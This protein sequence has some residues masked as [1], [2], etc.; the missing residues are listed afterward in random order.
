MMSIPRHLFVCAAF[1]AIAGSAAAQV[2]VV[3]DGVWRGALGAGFSNSTGN[4][5]SSSFNLNGDAVR[6]TS[7]DKWSVYGRGLYAKDDEGTTSDLIR[8]G[9]RYDRDLSQ[10]FFGFVGLDGERDGVADLSRRLT[11][12]LGVGYKII[13]AEPNTF[14]VFGGV[15]YTADK[16]SV[17]LEID[18]AFRERYN[19]ASLML[20][21]EST[22]AFTETVS[23]RQ[24][25]VV[26]PNLRNSGEYRAEFDAT[27]AVAMT[28]RLSL[29]VGYG[30]RFNSDPGVGKSRTDTLLT[31]GVAMKFE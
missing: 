10:R 28:S 21:E 1:G 8:L 18:G 22:H 7:G 9:T 16:Y 4:S 11:G 24:R 13:D 23:A 30:V 29:N 26:L 27:L 12:S 25:L 6:A 31:T 15:A 3:E 20:G 2:N 19:Y 14:N 5:R 17:P